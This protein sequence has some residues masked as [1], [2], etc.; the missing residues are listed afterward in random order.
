MS[1]SVFV[2]GDLPPLRHFQI[3]LETTPDGVEV[4][5]WN[6]VTGEGFRVG[7]GLTLAQATE[8]AEGVWQALHFAD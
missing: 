6:L 7:S 4:W 5:W 1:V 2:A 3:T 8:I